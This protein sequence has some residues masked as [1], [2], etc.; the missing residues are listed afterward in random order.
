[1]ARGAAAYQEVQVNSRSPLELVVMLYDGA[2]SSL[3]QTREALV[4]RDLV[5]KRAAMSK[6]LAIIGQL[7]SSLNMEEGREVAERL[8]SL[9][10]YLTSRLVEAN[11][12]GDVAPID[13]ALRVMSTLRDGWAQIATAPAVAAR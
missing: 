1:M 8:D 4:Q 13:E 3:G 9:Y 10:T 2:L 11:V 12:N 6:A 7:Q 5:T